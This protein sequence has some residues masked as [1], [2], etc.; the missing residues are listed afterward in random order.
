M[1]SGLSLSAAACSAATSSTARKALSLLRKPTRARF[2]SCSMK[3]WP[4]RLVGGLE[5]EE[6]GDPD[7]QRAQGFVAKVEVLVRETAALAGEDPVIRIL[8][9]VFGD[10][11]AKARPLLHALEDEVDAVSVVPRHAPL[12]GQ[13]YVPPHGEEIGFALDSPLEGDGFEPSVPRKAPEQ[14][15]SN[16]DVQHSCAALGHARLTHP[17]IRDDDRS[18]PRS[19]IA[20]RVALA[21]RDLIGLRR[22]TGDAIRFLW[23]RNGTLPALRPPLTRFSRG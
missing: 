23:N 13:D 15:R 8:G 9:G 2:S 22:R 14:T 4:L 6:R 11:D 21:C 17:T 7:H 19:M 12:P 3:L 20:G 5:R 10:A 16:G 1:M 18:Y